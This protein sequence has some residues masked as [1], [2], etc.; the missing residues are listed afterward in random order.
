MEN[1][2]QVFPVSL[3]ALRCCQKKQYHLAG[4]DGTIHLSQIASVSFAFWSFQHYPCWSVDG[5]LYQKY[6]WMHCFYREWC[7]E[8]LLTSNDN[9]DIVFFV[10]LMRPAGRQL[11]GWR[12]TVVY[13]QI[14]CLW[15]CFVQLNI[16]SH[17][18]LAVLYTVRLELNQVFIMDASACLKQEITSTDRHVLLLSCL[19]F[20]IKPH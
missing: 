5:R 6:L 18:F 14:V 12:A 16:L 9:K 8:R 20:L 13:S 19:S 11:L 10:S 4:V 15:K 17:A 7:K 2:H 1:S 3:S